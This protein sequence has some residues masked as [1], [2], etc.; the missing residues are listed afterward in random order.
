VITCAGDIEEGGAWNGKTG[1]E[2]HLESSMDFEEHQR[3]AFD[4]L[5]LLAGNLAVADNAAGQKLKELK[6]AYEAGDPAD[7]LHI[8]KGIHQPATNPHMQLQLKRG[9]WSYKFHLNVS[10]SSN[11][12]QGLPEEYFHWVGV[13]FT[14]DADTIPH[15]KVHA[16]WPLN[17]V[18]DMKN[19][20]SRRRLSIAPQDIQDTIN[21]IALAKQKAQDEANRQEQARQAQSK[22]DQTRNLIK[23]QL[24]K[25]VWTIEGNV[26][27]GLDKLI[28]G[29]TI[30]VTTKTRK[31]QRQIRWKYREAGV[32]FVA[33]RVSC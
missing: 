12:I 27:K 4:A 3:I 23:G 32:R 33:G 22:R 29:E 10:V 5:Q 30:A 26:N 9:N 2:K 6:D 24:G 21:A 19:R 7:V 1:L 25:Q 31:N 28:A 18:W 20:H 16:C 15:G 17:P 8:S 13:Q 14:A 11:R